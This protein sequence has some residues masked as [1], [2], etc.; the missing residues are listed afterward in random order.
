MSIVEYIRRV[1]ILSNTPFR[2]FPDGK[3]YFVENNRLYTRSEFNRMYPL[4]ISLRMNNSQNIDS[5]KRW[6]EVE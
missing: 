4:P 5:T 2:I 3:G 1:D 6:L